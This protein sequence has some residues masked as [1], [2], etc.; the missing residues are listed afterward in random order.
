MDDIKFYSKD[1]IADG[2]KQG[3]VGKEVGRYS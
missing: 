2:I 3:N 1:S